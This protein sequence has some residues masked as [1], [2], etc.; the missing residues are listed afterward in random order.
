MKQ[1]AVR[2][3]LLL[4]LIS[5]PAF[6]L[7]L[8]ILSQLVRL[9]I[10]FHVLFLLNLG[11]WCW[12]SNVHILAILG[13]DVGWLV[14][15]QDPNAVIGVDAGSGG[16]GVGKIGS[17]SSSSSSSSASSTVGSPYEDRKAISGVNTGLSISIPTASS[18]AASYSIMK[19]SSSSAPSAGLV[20]GPIELSIK[21]LYLIALGH[22]VLT[23]VTV[24]VF[25][26]L[27]GPW[28]EEASE[29]VPALT[30]LITLGFIWWPWGNHMF[31]RERGLFL[32]TMYRIALGGLG[33]TVFFCDVILA[34][35]LTSFSRVVGDLQIVFTDLLYNDPTHPA[36]RD[37]SKERR[38]VLSF[39]VRRL[40]GRSVD[41]E[42]EIVGETFVIGSLD[43]FNFDI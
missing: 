32:R 8:P 30:Y 11:L 40:T 9:P 6:I 3:L 39:A 19:P 43:Q 42:V 22:L 36:P 34:D 5:I 27:V 17:L 26:F 33:S 12:A 21:N 29:I 41:D 24:L 15:G 38:D 25:S 28:G 1:R 14:Q 10:Y 37:T 16:G 23:V 7:L 20:G 2:L 31:A 13:I 35:I 4:A 18:S